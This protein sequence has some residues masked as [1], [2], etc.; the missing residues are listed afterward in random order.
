MKKNVMLLASLALLLSTI[1]A[2][3]QLSS[4]LT[5]RIQKPPVTYN[6]PYEGILQ[7]NNLIIRSISSNTVPS[8]IMATNKNYFPLPANAER[9]SNATSPS[10]MGG[11][12]ENNCYKFSDTNAKGVST[13]CPVPPPRTL[14]PERS[15]NSPSLFIDPGFTTP[16][17]PAVSVAPL[18]QIEIS[19][20]SRLT[21]RNR[22]SASMSDF[23]IGDQIN[24][25]GFYNK[26]GTIKALI[27]RNLSK[28]EEKRYMQLENVQLIGIDKITGTPES[29]SSENSAT[30]VVI[31]K[32]NFPCY[33]FGAQGTV[34]KRESVCPLGLKS[35]DENQISRNVQV[36]STV[37]PFINTTRKYLVNVSNSTILIDKAKNRIT[38]KD[39]SIGDQ[40]HIYG[41]TS[42]KGEVI[43]A[44]IVR[45]ISKP[46]SADNFRGN[47]TQVN[48]DGSFVVKTDKGLL[49]TVQNPL[50]VG[51]YVNFKGVLDETKNIVDQISE[52]SIKSKL[53]VGTIT[54]GISSINPA[55]GYVGRK[56]TLDGYGFT[57]TGNAV[58]FGR[59]YIP[60]ISSFDG[61][62]LSF[63][64]P[65]NLVP[66]CSYPRQGQPV[67]L[68]PISLT[69]PG[70]YPVSVTNTN[71]TSNALEFSIP[72]ILTSDLKIYSY[73][74]GTATIQMLYSGMVSA[75]GGKD[76]YQWSVSNGILPPGL[77]LTEAVCITAPCQTP[78]SITGTPTT[79]GNYAFTITVQSGNESASKEFTLSILSGSLPGQ[80][81]NTSIR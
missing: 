23:S 20:D 38:L 78:I 8:L 75:N 43:H 44:E 70:K 65:E 53:G 11:A 21:L 74:L 12:K 26:D 61:T 24:V 46:I 42:G 34:K 33:D 71:G 76:S 81:N 18:Y 80:G 47:V 17:V 52:L 39:L 36:P 28:P 41:L 79:A 16:G 58:N 67:C 4:P 63:T 64:V 51:A 6:E 32:E 55:V 56:I 15:A 59:G 62:T 7:L 1:V 54:L 72:T 31:Q 22:E 66:A 30:L 60:N 45:N 40:L 3:A 10:N 29:P 77:H 35:F 57:P 69:T 68:M 37:T 49:V 19:N 5:Q 14:T 13:T 50:Q 9:E 73:S 25:F 27:V 48:N 2:N